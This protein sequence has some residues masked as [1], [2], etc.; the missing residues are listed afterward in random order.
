MRGELDRRPAMG[1]TDNA[2]T[3]LTQIL[4]DEAILV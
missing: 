1:S 3:A 4:V 2:P